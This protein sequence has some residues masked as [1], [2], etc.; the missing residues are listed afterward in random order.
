LIAIGGLAAL[1][2]VAT[3]ATNLGLLAATTA[4]IAVA[5][6]SLTMGRR[7]V[8]ESGAHERGWTKRRRASASRRSR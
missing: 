1:T 6:M 5:S 7:I 8:V 3:V 4:V 2:P